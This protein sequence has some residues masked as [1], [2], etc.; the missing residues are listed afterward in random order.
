M[1]IRV[2]IDTDKSELID[3]LKDGDFKRV[4]ATNGPYDKPLSVIHDTTVAGFQYVADCHAKTR[5]FLIAINSDKSLKRLAIQKA[6]GVGKARVDFESL[7]ERVDKVVSILSGEFKKQNAAI[8]FY[9]EDTPHEL[10]KA[11]HQSGIRMT[12]LHKWGYGTTPDA[13]SI[14]GAEFAKHVYGFTLPEKTADMK[15]TYWDFT[16]RDGNK[17]V[18]VVNLSRTQKPD[19]SGVYLPG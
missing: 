6:G 11:L 10:Y 13:P 4:H 9:D 3:G 14:A 17:S 16:P 8:V 1:S 7:R 18:R 5:D 15:P 2:L 19:G 12:S